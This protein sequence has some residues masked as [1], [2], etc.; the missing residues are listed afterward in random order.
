METRALLS[1]CAL[2]C[3]CLAAVSA[4]A[5]MA[6]MDDRWFAAL[7]QDGRDVH[8]QIQLIEEDPPNFDTTWKLVRGGEVLFE[9]R[10]FVREEADAV[11]GP[12]CIS[13][14]SVE[15]PL[16]CDEDG[17]AECWGLC[18]TA[19]RYGI[20]DDCVPEDHALY[21]LFDESTFDEDGNPPEGSDGYFRIVDIT[22]KDKSCLDSGG[23][24]V[25]AVSGRSS[26]AGLAALMLL[27]GLGFAV[28]ARRRGN[29]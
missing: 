17:D 19:Y 27:L 21:S 10:Q 1:V 20:V 16:D 11:V 12:G 15:A 4:R 6:S 25:A 13:V 8:F 2:A 24:S 18:G 7:T 26:E 9:N 22:A 28:V 14:N 23:C 5:N 29:R 3:L